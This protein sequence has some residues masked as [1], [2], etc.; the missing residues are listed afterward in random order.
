MK[1]NNKIQLITPEL[2]RIVAH[3]CADGYIIIGNQRRCKSE[4]LVHPRK[5]PI[6][7][8]YYVRYVNTDSFLV[9]Q[10]I[11][12]INK[13]FNRAVIRLRKHEYEI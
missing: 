11:E 12:D 3:V 6:R 13:Q 1:F 9:E 5:N 4:L 2:A 7:K 8:K 10:F